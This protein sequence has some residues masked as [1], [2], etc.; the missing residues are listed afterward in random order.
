[1]R[2]GEIRSFAQR[3]LDALL[4]FA[5]CVKIFSIKWTVSTKMDAN[6]QAMLWGANHLAG[7]VSKKR[8]SCEFGYSDEH[9]A[10]LKKLLEGIPFSP[11]K[12]YD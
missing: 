10:E 11:D 7:L 5:N 6:Y 9:Y 1:M 3:L 2:D 4:R 8:S 12:S